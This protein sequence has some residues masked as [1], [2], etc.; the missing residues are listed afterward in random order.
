MAISSIITYGSQGCDSKVLATKWDN[1]GATGVEA[2]QE[3]EHGKHFRA[4][5]AQQGP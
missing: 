4:R 3:V 1:M 5:G 2:K